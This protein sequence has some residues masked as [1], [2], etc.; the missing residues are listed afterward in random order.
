MTLNNISI[1]K[2]SDI[3]YIDIDDKNQ[4][5]MI[6]NQF[7]SEKLICDKD[8]VE[9]ISVVDNEIYFTQDTI[10]D[11]GRHMHDICSIDKSGGSFKVIMCDDTMFNTYSISYYDE[12]ENKHVKLKNPICDSGYV[13][14]YLNLCK[15]YS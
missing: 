14:P 8:I 2:D 15:K 1:I 4:L 13:K 6:G 7:E 9:I 10:H 5:Y 11:D 12:Y 3:Y